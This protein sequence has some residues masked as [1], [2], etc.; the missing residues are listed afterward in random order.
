M[1]LFHAA[2]K[3]RAVFDDEHVIA[4]G[5]LVPVM[6]LADRCRLPELVAEHVRI[7]DTGRE[8][9]GQDLLD[10]GGNDRGR[11]LDR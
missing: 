9:A 10:R 4:H 5:G 3:T 1:R 7:I 2:A 11:G 8:R 6:R